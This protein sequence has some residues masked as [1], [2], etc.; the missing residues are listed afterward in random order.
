MEKMTKREVLRRAEEVNAYGEKDGVK[1]ASFEDAAILLS[2][3]GIEGEPDSG[4]RKLNP[5]GSLARTK[6]SVQAINLDSAFANRFRVKTVKG[7]KELQIVN[8]ERA[9][10]DQMMGRTP[11]AAKI[12]AHVMVRE[13]KPDGSD[14]KLAYVR[15]IMVSDADFMTDFTNKLGVKEMVEIAPLIRNAETDISE[16]EMPI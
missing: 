14:G 6:T 2:A 13:H 15:T 9:I 5:D 10:R 12:P 7:E 16:S 8:D 11:Y 1:I 4:L 3:E